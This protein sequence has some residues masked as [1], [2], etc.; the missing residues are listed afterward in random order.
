L[1]ID[2]LFTSPQNLFASANEHIDE[3]G[4]GFRRVFEDDGGVI[5]KELDAETGDQIHWLKINA[6]L[7]PKLQVRVFNVSTELRASLDH[8]VYAATVAVGPH[9]TPRQTAFVFGD[10]AEDFERELSRRCAHVPAEIKAA[11]RGLKPYAGGNKTLWRLNKLRNVKD[12]RRLLLPEATSTSLRMRG[13]VWVGPDYRGPE[14]PSFKWRPAMPPR[15]YEIPIVRLP[16]GMEAHYEL[17]KTYGVVFGEPAELAGLGVID[18]LVA[19]REEVN[20]AMTDLRNAAAR[21]I[22]KRAAG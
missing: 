21:A 22:R 8:A 2:D 11:L 6:K 1:A 5:V 20:F 10:S 13:K 18:F 17:H 14:P 3:V 19:A 12:H 4:E 16:A 15:D 9:K 7:H